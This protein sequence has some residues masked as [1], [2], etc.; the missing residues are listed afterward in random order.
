MTNTYIKRWIRK[1]HQIDCTWNMCWLKNL[2][3]RFYKEC[4]LPIIYMSILKLSA[5]KPY[6]EGLIPIANNDQ[7]LIDV[8]KFRSLE[9]LQ[10]FLLSAI[11]VWTSNCVK[12]FYSVN[13]DR[14]DFALY[15]AKHCTH[16]HTVCEIRKCVHV[17]LR[18]ER[19]VANDWETGRKISESMWCLGS[20]KGKVGLADVVQRAIVGSESEI[21]AGWFHQH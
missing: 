4:D 20:W 21:K 10:D 5:Q 13:W 17:R 1:L 14:T 6:T 11:T 16:N 18:R 9:K 12:K 15:E 19:R 8:L 3:N 7:L 2:Q